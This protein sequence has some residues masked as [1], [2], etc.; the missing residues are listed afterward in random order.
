MY[1]ATITKINFND[2][3]INNNNNNSNNT[4]NNITNNGSP[5]SSLSSISSNSSSL[6]QQ[7]QQQQHQQYHNQQQQQHKMNSV[8]TSRPDLLN[9]QSS[10]TT[11]TSSFEKENDSG[12]EKDDSNTIFVR[13]SINDQN[14]QVIKELFLKFF[15]SIFFFLIACLKFLLKKIESFKVQSRRIDLVGQASSPLNSSQRD[16]RR[17]QLWLLYATTSRKSGKILGRLSSPQ[18]VFT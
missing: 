14:L 11:T 10:S 2:T 3:N 17:S 12:I 7:Q 1:S 9:L 13:V 8:L 4:H 5:N 6:L 18:R 15:F 16:K